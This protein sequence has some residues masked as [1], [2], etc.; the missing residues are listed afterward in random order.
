MGEGLCGQFAAM[1]MS[2]R[3]TIAIIFVQMICAYT[4]NTY[5]ACSMCVYTYTYSLI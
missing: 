1:V 4:Y 2:V 5:D 3:L